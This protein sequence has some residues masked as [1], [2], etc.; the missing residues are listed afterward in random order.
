MDYHFYICCY[1]SCFFG[2]TCIPGSLSE[3]TSSL[4]ENRGWYFKELVYS[5]TG[6][7]PFPT[8]FSEEKIIRRKN[9]L[10]EQYNSPSQAVSS[11]AMKKETKKE[12]L[13]SPCRFRRRYGDLP[14]RPTDRR[15]APWYDIKYPIFSDRSWFTPSDF[16]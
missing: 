15:G 1:K 11:S 9:L 10:L 6:V 12:T 8:R 5:R 4:Y 2:Q 3:N 16:H 13:P 14:T 7:Q